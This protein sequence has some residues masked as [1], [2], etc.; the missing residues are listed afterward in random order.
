MIANSRGVLKPDDILPEILRQNIENKFYYPPDQY[1]FIISLMKTVELSYD[2][3]DQ[4]VLVPSLVPA[5][6]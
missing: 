2:L 6:K 4:T 1:G 3:D 5:T